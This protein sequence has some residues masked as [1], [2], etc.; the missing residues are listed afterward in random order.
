[1]PLYHDHIVLVDASAGAFA[2]NLP[3]A[4]GIVGLGH[5]IQF[6]K[7]DASGNA[8]TINRNGADTIEGAASIA[9][10]AQYDKATLLS[11]GTSVWYRVSNE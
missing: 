11:D 4:S 7:A 8:V 3:S 10:A 9:L 1:V 6:I 5:P 2:V